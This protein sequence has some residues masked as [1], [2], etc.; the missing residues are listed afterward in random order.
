MPEIPKGD[1]DFF[2]NVCISGGS[3]GRFAGRAAKADITAEES[4]DGAE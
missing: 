4:A 1:K 2:Q 3:G